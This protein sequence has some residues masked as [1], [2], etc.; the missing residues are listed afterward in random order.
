MQCQG[1]VAG[2]L[3]P[4]LPHCHHQGT[5][6]P[7]GGQEPEFAPGSSSSRSSSGSRSSNIG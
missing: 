6:Q 4:G 7:W 2:A 1:R 3:P 5:H